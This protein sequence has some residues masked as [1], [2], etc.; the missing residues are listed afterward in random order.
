MRDVFQD[1]GID[2]ARRQV[3]LIPKAG[4]Q[5]FFRAAMH[6]AGGDLRAPEQQQVEAQVEILAERDRRLVKGMV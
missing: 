6:L 4:Q 2:L 3:P 1:V 5:R